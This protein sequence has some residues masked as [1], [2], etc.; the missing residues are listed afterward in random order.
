[1]SERLTRRA[2]N[3]ALLARQMLLERENMAVPDAVERL[4]GMQ[5]QLP[6]PPYIGLWTRLRRFERDDLTRLMGERQIV[7]A[8]MMR[9]TLHLVTAADHHRFRPTIQP[10]LVRALGAFFGKR[11]AGL[12]ADK[13]VQAVRPHLEAAPRSTGQLR[14]LLLEVEPERDPDA[15]AYL[16]R[17]YLPLIQV[18]PGGTWGS[19]S[20]A[21]YVT[22]ESW[23]GQP[24]T[25]GDLPTL[26]RRYLAAFGPASVQ[27]FQAW[28][29]LTKLKDA[30]QDVKSELR[31]FRDEAGREL[32]DLPQGSLPDADTPA[33]VRFIPEYDNLVLAHADRTRIIADE[34]RSKVYL[35]AG[36]VRSTF[37]VDGFVAGAWKAERKKNTAAL[38]IEPFVPLS[39]ENQEALT[40][41]GESLLRFIEDDAQHY[42]IHFADGE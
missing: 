19:G 21:A 39:S 13:L 7:R 25:E 40:R 16:V 26:F 22:A 37:L 4:L 31:T 11:A 15:M 17:T 18:P 14:A 23:L 36:R 35:S 34:H 30:F 32:F 8:A 12:D 6:N 9:S 41:E 1:M 38:T 5:A 24:D 28:S 42:E 2:L 10:A 33:P 27:D 29:G 3:R 20:S